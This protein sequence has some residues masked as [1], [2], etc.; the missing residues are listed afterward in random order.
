MLARCAAG[1]L[2]VHFDAFFASRQEAGRS[3]MSC[4]VQ[5]VIAF[6]SGYALACYIVARAVVSI[7]ATSLLTDHTNKDIS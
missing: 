1:P 3:A 4:V 5:A 7:I 6:H 2:T